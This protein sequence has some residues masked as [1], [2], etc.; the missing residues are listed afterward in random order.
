MEEN[1]LKTFRV[2][3]QYEEIARRADQLTTA[4]H[5]LANEN[6]VDER[7]VELYK[8]TLE[9]ERL[10]ES[11]DVVAVYRKA[12]VQLPGVVVERLENVQSFHAQLIENRKQFLQS[13][14]GRLERAIAER[15]GSIEAYTRERAELL[16]ILQTHGALQEFNSLSQLHLRTVAEFQDVSRRLE[17]LKAFE[18]GR[19]R[20]AIEQE[21]LLQRARRDLEERAEIR[22]E[23]IRLFNENSQALYSG[24]AG[25]LIIEVQSTGFRF[26]VEIERSGSQGIES[27]KVFCYDLTIA[28]LW[29][30]RSPSPKFLIHD[31]T[32]FDGVDERQVALALELAERK[33]RE[34]GFQYICTLNSDT[35]PWREFSPGFDLNEFVRLRL[36]DAD[37]AGRLLGVS[38]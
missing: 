30:K 24:A 20:V 7:Y 14:I 13:E 27:M 38:F 10:P 23:A 26:N 29:A 15:N 33:S 18:E 17:N 5:K 6:V 35:V 3:P 36:T 11:E 12:G 22:N 8:S 9:G 4:T 32:I 34:A 2:H 37:E 28:E 31:S 16:Q 19:S 25:S 1:Q 21:T